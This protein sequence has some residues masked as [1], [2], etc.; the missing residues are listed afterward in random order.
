M[1]PALRILLVEDSPADAELAVHELHRAGLS[2]VAETA[3]DEPSLRAALGR[4]VD[5]ILSDFNLPGIDGFDV[6]V[7]AREL[8]PRAPVI[9]VTGAT[10]EATAVACL[11]A[12][13]VDYIL[14]SQLGRIG[15]AV[16]A[17][18]DERRLQEERQSAEVLLRQSRDFHLTLL[19]KMPNPVWR[20][21]PYG[22][23]DYVNLE[24]REFLGCAE[25]AD[26]LETWLMGIH[27]D[28]AHRVVGEL[29]EAFA[30]RTALRSEYRLRHHDGSYHWI[31]NT[32]TPY[33]EHDGRFG[34]FLGAFFD[35]DE[36]RRH[37]G[38][39]ARLT[40]AIE[41]MDEVVII[42]DLAGRIVYV[43]P[44][45]E[46]VTGYARA[47]AL[48]ENPRFLKG[49]EQTPEQYAEMWRT[50]SAGG[51]FR[52]T[53]VNRRKSG[54]LYHT[55]VVISPVRDDRGA[56]THYVGLQ[57]DVTRQLQLEDQLRQSQKMEAIGRLAG[58]VAH[59]FN[60]ILTAITTSA[61]FLLEDL[62]AG[63]PRR[64]DVEVVRDSALRA[65]ALTRQ[66]LAFSRREIIEPR[67][68][69]LS[70]IITDTTR[71]LRRLIGEDVELVTHLCPEATPLLADP[72]QLEQVILNLAVN[73]RDAMPRGGRL[74]L[75]CHVDEARDRVCLIV[76][77]NGI[78][79]DEHTRAHLFEPFFTT[80]THGTGLGLATVYGIVSRLEGHITVESE[81]GRGTAFHIDLPRQDENP[82]SSSAGPREEAGRGSGGTVLVVEDEAPVRNIISRILTRTGYRVLAAGSAPEAL[83]LLRR[84]PGSLELLVTDLVLPGQ[85]GHV[86]AK[87]VAELRPGIKTLYIS[88]Y[89]EDTAAVREIQSARVSFLQKP[90]TPTALLHK[91]NATLRG[92]EPGA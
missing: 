35:I 2:F 9:M 71:M 84:H 68:C 88:G 57:R 81:T 92:E 5:V 31:V 34:G 26:Y 52:A 63:D 62:P 74:A 18:L 19:D 40:A 70:A 48:G 37:E 72:G 58:G 47:E 42:T 46:R 56:L 17:A 16:Q 28:D 13:A 73:A 36:R 59:D 44:A 20:S 61:H 78:G 10:S 38:E 11:K 41:Q 86:L 12:G 24:W 85:S 8:A 67:P 69:H 7:M 27:P 15:T 75:E 43:N 89:T 54:A 6:L 39:R 91:V 80:K 76:R 33:H 79:M 90:F 53:L 82:P 32:G 1:A 21:D 45:F 49:G 25:G 23:C 66:L 4:G 14:K 83:E 65:T 77:D 64:E 50:L 55:A 22:T 3:D 87:A 30:A 51:T 29:R 60:N